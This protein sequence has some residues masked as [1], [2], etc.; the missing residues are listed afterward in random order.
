MKYNR[1]R[2]FE[3]SQGTVCILDDIP[4]VL[5]SVSSESLSDSSELEDSS[6]F[7]NFELLKSGLN[8]F[9]SSSILFDLNLAARS[10]KLSFAILTSSLFQSHYHEI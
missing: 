9:F 10:R 3:L 7:L 8:S 1:Q 4:L 5:T 2:L 6:S